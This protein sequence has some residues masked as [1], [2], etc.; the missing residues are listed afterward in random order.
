MLIVLPSNFRLNMKTEKATCVLYLL[1][2]I[3]YRSKNQSWDVFLHI[4]SVHIC[5]LKKQK[6][7]ISVII[8]LFMIYCVSN[9]TYFYSYDYHKTQFWKQKMS[10]I[11]SQ[12][13]RTLYRF[14]LLPLAACSLAFLYFPSSLCVDEGKCCKFSKLIKYR[15]WTI[16]SVVS[17]LIE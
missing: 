11:V 16:C 10:L 17:L 14:L 1:H 8:I 7:K 3:P 9:D 5:V 15:I 6:R 4:N 13:G 2:G 12:S